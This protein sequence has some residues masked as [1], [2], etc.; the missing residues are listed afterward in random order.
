MRV[1]ETTGKFGAT[2]LLYT[3]I[4]S[5][6]KSLMGVD[7]RNSSGII[8]VFGGEGVQPGLF[9]NTMDCSELSFYVDSSRRTRLLNRLCRLVYNLHDEASPFCLAVSM[10]STLAAQ[11]LDSGADGMRLLLNLAS[12]KIGFPVTTK[13]ISGR[14]RLPSFRDFFST[15]VFDAV[16]LRFMIVGASGVGINLLMLKLQVY[17]LNIQPSLGVPLAFEGSVSWNYLL[18]SKFTFGE[19]ANKPVRFVLYNL[20]SI[21]SFFTQILAVYVLT[22]SLGGDYLLS[23]LLGIL[24]GF[25][26]NYLVSLRIWR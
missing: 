2:Q 17:L 1:D 9:G 5:I 4:K 16:L 7:L 22:R 21:G 6:R 18:N 11:A 24:A 14:P 13:V 10:P 25:I 20:S 8:L 26:L 3:E 12:R 19:G 23:S 15:S